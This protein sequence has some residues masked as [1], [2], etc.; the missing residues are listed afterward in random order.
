MYKTLYIVHC[1]IVIIIYFLCNQ[2]KFKVTEWPK[3]EYGK[4]YNGDS[5]II[6]NVSSAVI[7][8]KMKISSKTIKR[9]ERCYL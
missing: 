1:I 3:E 9:S 6:L 8:P 4:F 5:Y 7:P 2:Q